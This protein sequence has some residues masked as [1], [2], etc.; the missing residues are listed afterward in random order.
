MVSNLQHLC[1]ETHLLLPVMW[2]LPGHP[3]HGCPGV[4]LSFW[5]QRS[6]NQ[7]FLIYLFILSI[8]APS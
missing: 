7:N 6:G 2:G 3:H 5:N 1:T 4:I 8:S